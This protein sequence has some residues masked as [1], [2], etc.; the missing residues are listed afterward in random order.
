ML[1]VK[2]RGDVPDSLFEY[3]RNL[4]VES[5]LRFAKAV[6]DADDGQFNEYI[7]AYGDHEKEIADIAVTLTSDS[8]DKAISVMKSK[9]AE[10]YGEIPD[11]FFLCGQESGAS[12]GEA[13]GE[14]LKAQLED[15][16]TVLNSGIEDMLSV[17]FS[18]A[19]TQN[20]SSYSASYNFYGS[21]QTV[22]QQLRSARASAAVE[23][24]RGGYDI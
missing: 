13:F 23:R 20:N 21:G 11:E 18:N 7:T 12:F 4:D 1:G 9:L 3:L 2:E 6:L 22:A 24:L 16:R 17:G 10:V 5:G 14:E 8:T 15:I 19:G